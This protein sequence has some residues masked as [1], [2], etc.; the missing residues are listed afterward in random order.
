MEITLII[1]WLLLCALVGKVGEGRGHSLA[2]GFLVSLFLSPLVGL[3][4]VLV[5]SGDPKAKRKA[6][7][8]SGQLQVCPFC[9]EMIQRAAVVCPHCRNAI[10]TGRPGMA[11]SA[12]NDP[13]G[14]YG[15]MEDE[16]DEDT[17]R[18]AKAGEDLGEMTLKAIRR[19]VRRGELDT[20]NDHY[21]DS[22]AQQWESL[23]V[24]ADR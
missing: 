22:A 14:V 21:W 9:A 8:A 6:A 4:F 19:K 15:K 13:L 7:L 5:F 10:P 12:N 18:V 2:S 3:L 11:Q 20:V 24:I 17:F 1:V 16:E 23:G